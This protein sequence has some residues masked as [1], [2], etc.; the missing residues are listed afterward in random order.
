MT[1][2]ELCRPLPEDRSSR[3]G[4]RLEKAWV[5]ELKNAKSSGRDPKLV[6]AVIKAFGLSYAAL[7]FIHGFNELFLRQ[8]AENFGRSRPK[9]IRS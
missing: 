6:Y 8:V 1:V 3:L 7:A 2:N 5:K 9:S 4:N